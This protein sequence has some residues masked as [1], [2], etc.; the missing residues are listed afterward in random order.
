MFGMGYA[1][2][3][4]M[5]QST[6]HKGASMKVGSETP[7]GTAQTVDEIAKG[8]YGVT[9][10]SHGGIYLD[11]DHAQRVPNDIRESS[12]LGVSNWYEE[13]CDW[14][15]PYVLF[16]DEILEQGD[17]HQRDI[18]KK[19]IHRTAFERRHVA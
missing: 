8:I 10:A 1:L 15:I 12:F 5:S 6:Q 18:I 3:R 11:A 4:G 13:D 9:T 2:T 19:N 7:W 14:C 16:E 17:L